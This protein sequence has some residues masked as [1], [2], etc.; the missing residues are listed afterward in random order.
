[1]NIE[2]LNAWL[3]IL[4][5][6]GVIASLIFVGIQVRQTQS[7]GEGE[8]ATSFIEAVAATRGLV[9]AH[10]DIWVRGCKGEE[11]SD[12]ERAEFAHIVRAYNQVQYFAWLATRNGI[13]E[14]DGSEITY[15][16]AANIHRYPGFARMHES[17]RAWAKLGG[18]SHDSVGIYASEISAQVAE[19]QKSDPQP[20]YDAALCGL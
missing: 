20:E 15:A 12:S 2:K 10:A 1:L 4:G 19:L 13:L 5:I 9:A 14:M 3:Q 17:I 8:S 18:Y 6:L 11:L 16:V 7:I